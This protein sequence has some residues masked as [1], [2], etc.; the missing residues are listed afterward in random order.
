MSKLAPWMLDWAMNRMRTH[1][2]RSVCRA[3]HRPEHVLIALCD[4]F[5]PGWTGDPKLPGAAPKEICHERV[6]TWRRRY[7]AFVSDLRDSEGIPPRH[8]FFYPG[9]QYAFDLVEPLAQLVE[10]GL[11]DVEVHLHHE[12]D[13]RS[14][15]EAKLRQTL[16][17]LQAHGVVPHL[18]GRPRW[19]F[20]HGNWCLAN[21]RPD[22]AHCGVDD[23]LDLLHSMGCYADFTFPSA[24]D[25]T[26]PRIV[27]CIYYP[28]GDLR[29]RCAHER[30]EQAKVGDA[31]PNQLLCVQGP[32]AV[33]RRQG[34]GL[35]LRIDSGAITARDPATIARFE[36]WIAQGISIRGR[37]EWIFVKLSTHGASSREA[38]NLLGQTQR[39]FHEGLRDWSRRTGVRYHYVTA[40]E[41]FNVA[42]AAMD[43]KSGD[44]SYFRD[45]VV[46]SAPRA[47]SY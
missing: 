8:T 47:R 31:R 33:C 29:K 19:A 40:R 1:L 27:N 20:I 45:Y 12:N 42:R 3:K 16:E 30:G 46:A 28:E 23:E 32:L 2:S 41:L 36:T 15:L 38:S 10:M 25:P 34:R 9:D 22:G 4:H 26:Q 37:P 44:P 21:A 5:E 35:P 39:T 18:Q 6:V 14:S 11:A 13:T 43:G 24:P 7:P 17:D